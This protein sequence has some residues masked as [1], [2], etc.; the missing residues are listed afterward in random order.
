MAAAPAPQVC[1]MLRGI[2]KTFGPIVAVDGVD[3]E[4]RT[5]EIHAV[6]GENGAGKSTLMG[7]LHGLHA[8]DAGEIVVD[9]VTRSFR[10]PRE[11]IALGIG[12]VHQHFMLAA[13][14]TAAENIV[15]GF[16]PGTATRSSLSEAVSL[17][18]TVAE[19]FD[20]RVALDRPVR[21]LAIGAQQRV[22]VLKALYRG[23]R[24]LILDEPTAV[25][26]PDEVESLFD[27]LRILR[28]GGITIVF[29]SHKLR[30]VMALSD[31][32]TVMR[33]G[34]TVATLAT[35]ETTRE[36]LAGLMV[37]SDASTNKPSVP[38]G[39]VAGG[40][41]ALSLRGIATPP[42]PGNAG[43]KSL[44][45]DIAA[46]E[47]VGIAAIEGNGQADLLEIAAGVQ[48]PLRG[49]VAMFGRDVTGEDIGR[50]RDVGLAYVPEDRHR[51]ALALD[52][53]ALESFNAVRR[54]QHW[55]DWLR[56]AAS[57][58]ER[59]RVA[60]LMRKFDVRPP[61]PLATC[62]SMSGGNQQKLVFAREFSRDP[63][64]I[65]LGQ[66]TR[67]IDI[68]ASQAL[69]GRIWAARDRGAGV[70][71]V[72]ADL[73]ELFTVADRIVVL[74]EGCLAASLD[75]ASAAPRDAGLYMTGA[76]HAI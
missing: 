59:R 75:P 64:V 28:A 23:A 26:S 49:T 8:A 11:A 3:L 35:T 45:L 32:V 57:R 65:V 39:R 31:R 36:Q 37:G 40:S 55:S 71:L 30:E 10:S 9:G 54:P 19:R 13:S 7:V 52:A 60:E 68:G 33:R 18:R 41:P 21:D 29:I 70:L 1:V 56:P 5:G 72:S 46:G 74:Y 6:V 63:K 73:D 44:D 15:L 17:G 25:L 43:L 51:D 50:R 34:R 2:T 22:E 53:T 66:P 42:R 20:L 48:A 67:G 27:R 69:F 4:L 24:I 38:K 58:S 61:D 14:L 76:R 12:M 47:I 62:R 16:E